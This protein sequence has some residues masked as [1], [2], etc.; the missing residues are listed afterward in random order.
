MNVPESA[1]RCL[2]TPGSVSTSVVEGIFERLSSPIPSKPFITNF[3]EVYDY[4]I[5]SVQVWEVSE[6]LCL[7]SQCI[8]RVV[9][10]SL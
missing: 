10:A 7:Y 1:S 2:Q 9:N 3:Q 8:S 6:I 4:F 5:W